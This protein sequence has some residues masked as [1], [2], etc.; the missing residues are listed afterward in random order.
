MG[1]WEEG[2]EATLRRLC[3]EALVISLRIAK[4]L[5]AIEKH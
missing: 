5:N 3:W 4:L 2:E 1:S